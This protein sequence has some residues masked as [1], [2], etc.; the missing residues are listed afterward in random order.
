M[1]LTV[2]TLVTISCYSLSNF[3]HS[4]FHDSACTKGS[5]TTLAWPALQDWG[6]CCLWCSYKLRAALEESYSMEG[7]QPFLQRQNLLA[8][9]CLDQDWANFLD[10]EP[11]S[12]WA[13]W[14]WNYLCLLKGECWSCYNNSRGQSNAA[15]H[16]G[17]KS[18]EL[19]CSGLKIDCYISFLIRIIN[20]WRTP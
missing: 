4:L 15:C 11:F 18:R 3:K 10:S 12:C 1:L 7:I 8:W 9:W 5:K 16:E 20:Y 6:E 14:P 2:W 13:R 19:A 17:R